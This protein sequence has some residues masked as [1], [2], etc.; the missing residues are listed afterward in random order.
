MVYLGT[1][2]I[3]KDIEQLPNDGVGQPW[4][5]PAGEEQDEL[6]E[7][8]AMS[9]KNVFLQHHQQRLKHKRETGGAENGMVSKDR[10]DMGI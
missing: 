10:V 9:G 7:L 3:M 1:G 6:N 2:V 4:R 5:P 8:A